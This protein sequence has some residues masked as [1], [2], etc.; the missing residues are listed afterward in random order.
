MLNHEFDHVRQ[1][2]AGSQLQGDESEVDACTLTFCR[3]FHRSYIVEVRGTN[4][5]I[6]QYGTFSNLLAYYVDTS[7]TDGVRQ[8]TRLRI[9]DYHAQTIAPH[10]VHAREFSAGGS[11]ARSNRVR[12]RGSRPS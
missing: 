5:L 11:T 4:A 1:H 7:V 10:P 6:N 2:Q 9:R 3:D 12:T 8:T